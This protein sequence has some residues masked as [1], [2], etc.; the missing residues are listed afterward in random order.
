VTTNLLR[1]GVGYEMTIAVP[2][3]EAFESQESFTPGSGF[4]A[5]QTQK[6]DAGYEQ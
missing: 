5:R 1:F 4:G 2:T 3:L 6:G